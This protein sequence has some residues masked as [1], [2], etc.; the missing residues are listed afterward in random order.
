MMAEAA[1]LGADAGQV[2]P[3]RRV[4]GGPG[5]PAGTGPAGGLARRGVAGAET[6]GGSAGN[7]GAHRTRTINSLLWRVHELDPERAPEPRS[8]DLAKHQQ[9]SAVLAAQPDGIVAE[10]ALD[11]LDD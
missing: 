3:D 1:R 9:A 2:G 6:A 10:L 4:G 7:V 11:E 5:V 8:L